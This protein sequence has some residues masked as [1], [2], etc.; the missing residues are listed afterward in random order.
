[1]AVTTTA[2]AAEGTSSRKT[3]RT[4]K[5]VMTKMRTKSSR[6]RRPGLVLDWLNCEHDAITRKAEPGRRVRL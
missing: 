3:S 1:M 5:M 6:L 4:A 2:A